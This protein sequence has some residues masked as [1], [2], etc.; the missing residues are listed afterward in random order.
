LLPVIEKFAK[1][2]L[3]VRKRYAKEFRNLLEEYDSELKPLLTDE[4][5]K[6]MEFFSRRRPPHE[7]SREFRP[8]PEKHRERNGLRMP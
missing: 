1:K 6:K 7:G 8:K 5:I 4:Q 2:N 3:E